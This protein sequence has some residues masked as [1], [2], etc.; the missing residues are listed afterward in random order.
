MLIYIIF[1][2]VIKNIK[3][4]HIWY[5]GRALAE[6]VETLTWHFMTE[7]EFFDNS[8]RKKPN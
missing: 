2:L 8:F 6:S 5:R 1:S 4:E 7:S 3:H